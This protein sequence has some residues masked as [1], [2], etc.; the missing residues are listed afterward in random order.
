MPRRKQRNLNRRKTNEEFIEDAI[1]I[2]D[3]KYDYS[4]VVYKSAHTKVKI[5]CNTHDEIFE[6]KP[7]DHLSGY[8][9][10]K[11][12]AEN[13]S[14]R[15]SLG[16]KEFIKRAR[17]IHG[18]EYDYSLVEYINN[19]TKIKITCQE[20]GIFEQ[21]PYHHLKSLGC[22]NCS[23]NIKLTINDFIERAIKVHGKLYDY[24]LVIYKNSQTKIKIIC[25]THGVFEQSPDCHLN[26]SQGCPICK[27]SK[28]ELKII[29]LLDFMGIK[30]ET[31]K[32]FDKCKNKRKLSFD[33]YL[34]ENNVC[35]EFDGRQHFESVD[36]YGGENG[37]NKTQLRDRIKDN[38]C[39]NNDIILYRIRY[40]ENIEEKMNTILNKH[41][42]Y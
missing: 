24:S 19:R 7:N 28:G 14:K 9:C 30:Y 36:F 16:K 33:F 35:I 26:R 2:H 25:R 6:Q 4:L 5:I 18:N 13:A 21:Q 27:L 1:E 32:T 29:N 3:N 23:G 10:I 31:Q 20:H 15:Y 17:Q 34:S 12:A 42:L 22:P 38:Y 11:C 39:K 8:G 40:D 37:F 41:L